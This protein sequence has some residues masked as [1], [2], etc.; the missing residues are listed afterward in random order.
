M[1]KTV[2]ILGCGWLGLPLAKHLLEAGY[3]VKGS[4][5]TGTKVSALYALD[6]EPYLMEI[7][8]EIMDTAAFAPFFEADVLVVTLP[9]GSRNP[10]YE[11]PYPAQ[12]RWIRK[13]VMAQK[14]PPRV[15][16]ISSTS[17]YA[18]EKKE[19]FEENVTSEEEAGNKTIFRAEKVWLEKDKPDSTILR[20]GGLLGE[21][22]I[23]GKYFAGKEI[24]TG[25]VPVNFIHQVDVIQIISRLI[26]QRGNFSVYNLV[27]PQ[28]PKREVVYRANAEAFGF[29][30]P[31]FVEPDEIPSYKIVN[32]DRVRSDLNY[33]FR[34][35][36]PIL[37]EYT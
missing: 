25:D 31:I 21:Q 3:T 14:T 30:L 6:V 26:R 34:Y 11:S 36:D 35:P 4:T 10:G 7:E 2:S 28:H 23:P 37:F 24:K 9:P 33:E 29:D 16:M 15:I 22:R 17:V 5:T 1:D 18:G 20:C 8:P 12:M 13:Q 32:S 19:V 27:A